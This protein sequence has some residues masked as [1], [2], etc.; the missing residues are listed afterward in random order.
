MAFCGFTVRIHPFDTAQNVF[1]C[2]F[3]YLCNELNSLSI[4]KVYCDAFLMSWKKV[5]AAGTSFN[6]IPAFGD[7]SPAMSKYMLISGMN[8]KKEWA[9]KVSYMPVEINSRSTLTSSNK[10]I[11][12][13]DYPSTAEKASRDLFYDAFATGLVEVNRL[14]YCLSSDEYS[15]DEKRKLMYGSDQILV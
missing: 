8:F 5:V 4:L 15:K 13:G 3:T 10:G 6:E 14:Y 1:Q 11:L 2:A 12:V 7:V 9:D